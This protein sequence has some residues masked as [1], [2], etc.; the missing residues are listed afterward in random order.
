MAKKQPKAAKKREAKRRET[1][2]HLQT[3]EVVALLKE[4]LAHLEAQGGRD[5]PIA[6][7]VREIIRPAD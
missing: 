7:K 1:K 2:V 6:G 4:V 3:A 5:L